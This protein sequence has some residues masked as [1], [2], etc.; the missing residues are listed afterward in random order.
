[1]SIHDYLCVCICIVM[2]IQLP[3]HLN[4]NLHL[5]L[6]LHIMRIHIYIYNIYLWLYLH[7]V[8][9]VSTYASLYLITSICTVCNLHVQMYIIWSEHHQQTLHIDLRRLVF[10]VV[11]ARLVRC[12]KAYCTL[13]YAALP[14]QPQHWA[15]G[16]GAMAH[17]NHSQVTSTSS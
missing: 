8:V 5:H 6:H 9:L 3:L 2:D 4:L 7:P 16:H 11:E 10:L 12:K 17:Q 1:M 14:Q 15:M 13:Q